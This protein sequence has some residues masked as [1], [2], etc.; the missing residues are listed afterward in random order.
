MRGSRTMRGRASSGS[1]GGRRCAGGTTGSTTG[2]GGAGCVPGDDLVDETFVVHVEALD[3]ARTGDAAAASADAVHQGCKDLLRDA[4][5]APAHVKAVL[6]L[7]GCTHAP[8]PQAHVDSAR[9]PTG[10]HTCGACMLWAG[11][12]AC[13]GHTHGNRLVRRAAYGRRAK[14]VQ[15]CADRGTAWGLC[16]CILP[17]MTSQATQACR[18]QGAP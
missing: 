15:R 10:P 8:T 9:I 3:E 16:R 6:M 5:A 11:M 12:R 18:C 2:W 17:R 7:Q 4:A 14:T 1:A 13:H